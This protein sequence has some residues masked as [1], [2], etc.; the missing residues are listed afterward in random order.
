MM[1]GVNFRKYIILICVCCTFFVTKNLY[2][3]YGNSTRTEDNNYI[4]KDSLSGL[5]AKAKAIIANIS[6]NIHQ[7]FSDAFSEKDTDFLSN[8]QDQNLGAGYSLPLSGKL[9]MGDRIREFPRKDMKFAGKT[10]PK[11]NG[12]DIDLLEKHRLNYKYNCDKWAVVTTVFEPPTEAVRRF[13][14]RK[15]WCVVVAGDK[16]KPSLE[17]IIFLHVW[18]QRT[19]MISFLIPLSKS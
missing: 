6:S 15:D 2:Y 3:N 9:F 8:V 11:L 5:S 1:Y 4:L 14:Y 17:V 18:Q 16:G 19:L 12:D 10:A 13:M 7:N